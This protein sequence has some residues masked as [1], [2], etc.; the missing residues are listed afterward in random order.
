MEHLAGALR[1]VDT[2]EAREEAKGLLLDALWVE[3]AKDIIKLSAMERLLGS[4]LDVHRETEDLA[5]LD[6]CQEAINMGLDNLHARKVNE[7]EAASYAALLRR[8]AQVLLA[9]APDANA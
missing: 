4:V 8:I 2:P 7:V 1:K 3:C 9:Y 5:G 6:R